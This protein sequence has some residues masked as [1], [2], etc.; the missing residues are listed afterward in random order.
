ME[1]GNGV[2]ENGGSIL[3]QVRGQ[4]VEVLQRRENNK[5]KSLPP[6]AVALFSHLDPLTDTVTLLSLSGI[7]CDGQRTSQS[8]TQAG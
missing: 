2:E 7:G 6:P 1:I 8:Q 5:E 3:G 4:A